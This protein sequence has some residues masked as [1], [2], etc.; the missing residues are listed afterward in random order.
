MTSSGGRRGD[1]W[2]T[3]HPGRPR[4]GELEDVARRRRAATTR[5]PASRSACFADRRGRSRQ[6]PFRPRRRPGPRS[7]RLH[8]VPSGPRETT[9]SSTPQTCG[10]PG[11]GPCVL[12][13][14]GIAGDLARRRPARHLR[15]RQPR[16]ASR[17]LAGGRRTA[18]LDRRRASRPTWRGGAGRRPAP[19]APGDLKRWLPGC[20]RPFSSFEDDYPPTPTSPRWSAAGRHRGTSPGNHACPV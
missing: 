12:V 16:S 19:V 6:A 2:R 1:R 5:R 15:P 17:L 18:L 11:G 3:G 13:M 20:G 7:S 4:R 10:C 14:F 8:H 9:P